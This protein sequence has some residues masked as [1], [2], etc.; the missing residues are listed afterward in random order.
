MK[1]LQDF[2]S[3]WNWG[4]GKL[5][6]FTT[7][8]AYTE[9]MMES[10]RKSYCYDNT[11]RNPISISQLYKPFGFLLLAARG[12]TPPYQHSL[13]RQF[14]L[15]T[16][17]VWENIIL[18]LLADYDYG[19]ENE[20]VTV[21]FHG[22]KGHVD[23]TMNDNV[24]DIKTMSHSY[25]TSF[26]KEP[27]DDRG[28]I[29]QIL[30]YREALGVSGAQIL[31]VNKSTGHMS[32][33]DVDA[34]E[35]I[36]RD[37]QLISHQQLLDRAKQIVER[38]DYNYSLRKIVE[39]FILTVHLPE[40]VKG[41]KLPYSLQYDK[42]SSLVWETDKNGYVVNTFDVDTICKNIVEYRDNECTDTVHT[43]RDSN[44]S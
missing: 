17:N 12:I 26:V 6:E 44:V 20:Q 23:F 30:C 18:Q 28:Y 34:H 37:N 43:D 32:L 27:N 11:V 9:A 41:V 1:T 39:N 38:K 5:D 16:G 29:T 3:Q 4:C 42:R 15:M 7:T 40:H 24:V 33:V 21:D 35:D 19:F 10:Y 2:V 13:K 14:H 8:N 36:V 25:Y 22:C 31:C